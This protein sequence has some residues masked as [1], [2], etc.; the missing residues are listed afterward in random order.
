MRYLLIALSLLLCL[1]LYTLSDLE[2]LKRTKEWGADFIF[3]KEIEISGNDI[4]STEQISRALP[5]S[6]PLFLWW[7]NTSVI[8]S[9]LLKY[10]IISEANIERCKRSNSW[11]CFHLSLK[12]R[13]ASFL[14]EVNN[15][16]WILG[17]D[18]TFLLPLEVKDVKREVELLLD[19]EVRPLVLLQGLQADVNAPDLIRGRVAYL[20]QAITVLTSEVKRRPRVID[21]TN[22]GEMKVSFQNGGFKATFG[23]HGADL[24]TVGEEARRLALLLQKFPGREHQIK[25][26][27][28][29]F[30][31]V[32][33]VQFIHDSDSPLASQKS[34][35]TKR[36]KG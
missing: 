19:R 23:F 13:E 29:A 16:I 15:K 18:G 28:L 22:Q 7:L 6:S 5:L 25:E 17:P 34:D 8:E 36:S 2:Y 21:M 32:A 20:S 4:L 9:E 14:A 30:K 26:I 24:S 33:V 10:P 11:R 31:K 3:R 35:Q 27:D 12:E 1:E